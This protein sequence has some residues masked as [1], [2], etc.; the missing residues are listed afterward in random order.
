[1]FKGE[2]AGELL[3]QA[4]EHYIA[5]L[6]SGWDRYENAIAAAYAGDADRLVDCLRAHKP[7]ADGDRDCLVIYIGKK[8]RRRRW[9]PRLA[10]ALGRPP[11][12]ND[13]D[14]LADLVAKVGRKR[15]RGFDAPA[16]RAARLARVLL[17]LW[18]GRISARLRTAMIAYA[19]KTEG[20]ESGVAI[21]SERVRNLLDHPTARAHRL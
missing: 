21:E 17:S 1:V 18:A 13:Y 6:R 8:I 12:A 20:D 10:H 15:G 2:S 14:L 19:C 7:L 3:R 4:R 9:T 16:H 5:R 11:T